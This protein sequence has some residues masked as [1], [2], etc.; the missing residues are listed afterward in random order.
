MRSFLVK[1]TLILIIVSL[2]F[3]ILIPVGNVFYI[4]PSFKLA[5]IKNA[6]IEAERITQYFVKELLV[7]GNLPK[8][9]SKADQKIQ[10]L[11]QPLNF[12]KMRIFSPTGTI[13]Y[14]TKNEEIGTQN[15]K[16]YFHEIVS[17]GQKFT[18]VVEKNTGKTQ[19]GI[20]LT[21]DVVESYVPV[22]DGDKFIGAFELYYDITD[23]S[24][25][26]SKVIS[27]VSFTTF[28]G[29]VILLILA[30]FFVFRE[31]EKIV[32]PDKHLSF[33]YRSPFVP[34]IIM[35]IFIFLAEGVVMLI[36]SG[37]S[38]L[39]IVSEIILDASFLSI[40]VKQVVAFS[41]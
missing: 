18:K 22:M 14:S 3:A 41:K 12:F 36:L 9:F 20:S 27:R 13:I 40:D 24:E 38:E 5:I 16:K 4:F 33:I 23:R 11:K 1:Q 35:G 15:T 26:F 21:I 6:E 7:G 2:L 8:K 19:E 30:N 17:L 25:R 34:P 31:R 29:I 10:I 37:W 28:A 32:L 39:S